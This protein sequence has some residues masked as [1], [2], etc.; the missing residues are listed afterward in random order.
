MGSV[1]LLKLGLE[2][3]C[4]GCHVICFFTVAI[5]PETQICILHAEQVRLLVLFGARASVRLGC[6]ITK[7]CL[8]LGRRQRKH[9]IGACQENIG[10]LQTTKLRVSVLLGDEAFE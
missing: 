7:P 9:F 6:G 5:Y 2:P 8:G 3:L 10:M 1:S 4:N